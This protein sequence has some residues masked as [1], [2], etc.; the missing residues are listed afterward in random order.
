MDTRSIV[1]KAR[2]FFWGEVQSFLDIRTIFWTRA[3]FFGRAQYFERC[4]KYSG[5]S[6]NFFGHHHN[7]LPGTNFCVQQH[8]FLGV[9]LIF[10]YDST[11]FEWGAQN[12][13]D[14]RIFFSG[15]SR[16]F[17]EVHICFWLRAQFFGSGTMFSISD[18]FFVRLHFWK[19]HKIFWL[20]A[21]LLGRATIFSGCYC[22]YWEAHII[23]WAS[24]RFFWTRIIFSSRNNIFV[25]LI[26]F[27]AHNFSAQHK[28]FWE[29]HK[30]FWLRPQFFRTLYNF[31]EAHKFF[32]TSAKFLR[33][34]QNF[35][36]NR[37]QFFWTGAQF[38]PRRSK[39]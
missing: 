16:F 36:D 1:W 18:Q 8:N 39:F 7:F 2:T 25:R 4:I 3:Q 13:L 28:I 21:Q 38:F 29:V 34:A 19:V 30:R 31:L 6:H 14:G 17:W 35:L 11:I 24:A 26:Q 23:F 10:R 12:F 33:D 32:C 15:Q 27:S 22:N 37:P 9:P 20:R 5:Y